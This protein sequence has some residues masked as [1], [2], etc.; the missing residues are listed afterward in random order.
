LLTVEVTTIG[1]VPPPVPMSAEFDRAGGS[2][3]RDSAC[4]LV[5]PDAEKRISRSHAVISFAAGRFTV[6]G[7]GTALPL[8]VND[9][10][11]EFGAE[12]P[13]ADGDRIVI[14]EYSMLVHDVPERKGVARVAATAPAPVRAQIPEDFDPFREP[15]IV[16]APSAPA[17]RRPVSGDFSDLVPPQQGNI[18]ELFGLRGGEPLPPGHP[19][20]PGTA[21]LTPGPVGIDDLLR[22]GAGAAPAP[23]KPF[24][25]VQ[26]DDASELSARIRLPD[27]TRAEREQPAPPTP[28]P[29]AGRV[30]GRS[31]TEGMKLSWESEAEEGLFDGKRTMVIGSDIAEG[32][33]G[34][35]GSSTAAPAAAAPAP[36]S[37]TA[38][39]PILLRALLEGLGLER[40]PAGRDVDAD[41]MRR[42]G[43]L[44]RTAVQGTI[45]LLR[46][47]AAIKSEVKAEMTRM[48][49]ADNNPLK[50]S[51]NVEAAL[52]YLLGPAQ[53]GFMSGNA[54]MD[55][56]YRD[57]VAHLFGFT[58]GTRAALEAMLARFDPSAL[59][60][61]LAA[62]SV[63]DNLMPDR[64]K[65]KLWDLFTAR[66]GQIAAEA[67]D[68]FQRVFGKEF[69][70]AY[71]A[72]VAKLSEPQRAEKA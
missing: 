29:S 30:A 5:L 22:P 9:V 58:A 33:R 32:D 11:V 1:G 35:R 67:E 23:E 8:L 16:P 60:H 70:R 41:Q 40:W 43:Q 44:L 19:L 7:H 2:I 12:V 20:R 3:G 72:Q 49:S 37:A 55:E 45:D 24:A 14:G 61:R 63:L 26:R 71:G 13:L 46:A 10:P 47:R 51:P 54:A 18:D 59:E 57:L 62:R 66:F 27:V 38:F 34:E 53:R 39:D 4:T 15:S 65:A 52:V 28:P 17:E 48:V 42:L 68:D 64:R 25:P 36:R 69:L 50:F 56:A 6:R 21:A 31:T